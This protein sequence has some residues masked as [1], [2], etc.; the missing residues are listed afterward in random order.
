MGAV[1]AAF[2]QRQRIFETLGGEEG[3]LG[4]ALGD[5]GIGGARGAIDQDIG[6]CQK[7]RQFDAQI[8]GN[9]AQRTRHAIEN[10]LGRCQGFA[11]MKL[12]LGVEHHDIGKCSARIHGNSV[13]GHQNPHIGA[14]K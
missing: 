1:L 5:H 4:G 2:L 12:A 14:P 11:D 3:S 9:H 13:A 6:A 10:P 8:F 7:L